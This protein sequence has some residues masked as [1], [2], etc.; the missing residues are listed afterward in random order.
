MCGAGPRPSHHHRIPFVS[1]CIEARCVLLINLSAGTP[2]SD[3]WIDENPETFSHFP[4]AFSNCGRTLVRR[5]RSSVQSKCTS[6]CINWSKGMCVCWGSVPD[7]EVSSWAYIVG[8][9]PAG[10][11]L[12]SSGLAFVHLRYI[13]VY[14]PLDRPVI[15]LKSPASTSYFLKLNRFICN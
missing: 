4:L 5:L 6:L 12:T 8:L 14:I 7:R 15:H 13:L 3:G 11:M 10:Y 1:L 9:N 2:Q